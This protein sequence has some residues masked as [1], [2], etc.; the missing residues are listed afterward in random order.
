MNHMNKAGLLDSSAYLEFLQSKFRFGAEHGFSVPRNAI[1]PLAK[2]HQADLIQWACR[3]G[4]AAIFASFGLGKSIMQLEIERLMLAEVGGR[5][6]IIM[7][8]DVRHEFMADAAMLGIQVK[9]IRSTEEIGGAGIYL[10]NYESVREGKIDLSLFKVASLDEAS[11]LRSYGSKTYQVFIDLFQIVP[12]RFVATATP[13]PN[14]YK[15]LIHYAGF[16][17]IADTGQALTRFFQRDSEQAN[18]LTLYP[19]MEK[20]F[21]LWL[22]SW[23]AFVQKPSDLGYSDEGYSL[24][25]LVVRWHEVPVD[26]LQGKVER[27]GQG[28]LITDGAVGLARA[29][30]EKRNTLDRRIA[31][32]CEIVN[33]SPEEHFILWHDLESERHAICGALPEARAVYGSQDDE[34]RARTIMDFKEGK[35]RLLATKKEISG[36]GGNFQRFCHR[37]I[38]VGIDHKFNDFVQAIHR[39]H[40]FLQSHPCEID[41]I[42]AETERPVRESLERKWGEHRELTERMSDLIREHGL[43]TAGVE[44]ELARTIGVER[45]EARGA[46]WTAVHNDT[47]LEADRMKSDSVDLIVT[48]VPF[49]NHYEYSESYE[50]FGHNSDNGRFFQQMEFLTPNLLRIL[51]PGRLACIHV[52]DRIRYGNVTGLGMPSV[53]PFHVD[54]IQHYRRHG[55]VYMGMITVVTDVVRENNQT[56]RLGWTEQCKDGSKMGVGCP[57]Y[58]LLFRKLP[59]DT[60][61][62]YADVPVVKDKAQY[63]RGRWQVDAHAFWR[64][65]GN[66]FLTADELLGFG[67]DVLAKHFTLMTRERVYD[68]GAHVAVAEDMDRRGVLPA[69]FMAVAPGSHDPTVWDDVIRMR[70][71]NGA[72][73]QRNLQQHVCPLQ[74]DIVERLINRYTN[75]GE[76]VYD[77]FHGLGTVSYCAL[78]LGRK[79]AGVEL[80]HEYWTDS[81]RHLREAEREASMPSLFDIA[82]IAAVA[83]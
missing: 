32:M 16:L 9:F 80:N 29:A 40:R 62:A 54:C 68:H 82:E 38:F 24:P 78:K 46:G 17:G 66:R 44:A 61:T 51:R 10:T 11:V 47:V 64:S 23:A 71:L 55:F 60:S 36:S 15:E 70:T 58:V 37:A 6:L 45:K 75:P 59:S 7:P 63:T 5:G 14:Q 33:A 1:T 53:E 4:R 34:D 69:T 67:P 42:F 21:F 49:G 56:Y 83:S 31:K 43:A 2:T 18:N 12:Y 57:E 25:E 3:K 26:S 74:F 50:D 79:G 52:K 28:V 27:D 13:S 73:A 39:I 81:L 76:L 8:L 41:I 22:H 48:S 20:E 77:P 72:Q 35:L 19:H 65:S 30:E